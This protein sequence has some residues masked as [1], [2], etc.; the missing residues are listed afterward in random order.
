MQYRHLEELVSGWA[1]EHG[2]K[3]AKDITSY[4]LESWYASPEWSPDGSLIAFTRRGQ[5]G[6]RI[7]VVKPD[8]TGERVLTS[9]PSDE[10]ASW[11]PSSRKLLFQRIAANGRTGLYRITLDGSEPRRMTIPEDGSDPDWSGVMD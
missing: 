3:Y 10:G 2:I 11:A 5:D 1:L 7:G 4:Q 8:G 6:R 9:G